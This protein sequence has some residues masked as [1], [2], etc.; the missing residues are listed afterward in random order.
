MKAAVFSGTPSPFTKAVSVEE[1]PTPEITQDEILI[2]AVSYAI[3]PTDWK[4]VE[5][6][7][8]K[9]G[10]VLGSDV[11]GTVVKVGSNVK[12]FQ[13]GDS[14][15]SFV[16]GNTSSKNGAFAQYVVGHPNG[17]IK[18]DAKLS[19][20]TDAAPGLIKSYPGAASV[21]LGLVTIGISFSYCLRPDERGSKDGENYILIW[22]GATASGMLAIQ[23]A[24]LV[25]NLKV[26][27]TAS[28]K[29]HE[30]LKS[31]GADYTFDYNDADV[32]EQIKKVGGANLRFGL[33]TIAVPETFQKVYDATAEV[34]GDLYLDSL[35]LM[36][37]SSITL[38]DKRDNSKIH[39]GKTMAY[40]VLQ[41]TKDLIS[42]LQRPEGLLKYYE[43]WWFNVM[44]K[45]IGQIQHPKLK[46]LP[47]GLQ[48]AGEGFELLKQ[49]VSSEK[50]VFDY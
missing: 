4:H 9:Q 45:Y 33:D 30:Y 27:T 36:D 25:Y 39:Y 50:I 46:V 40:L 42:L 47:K 6:G 22:G 19:K 41:E 49:G 16:S 43:P 31:L 18:Y 1:I 11:S 20:E 32:V 13:V 23:V 38:D 34:S 3:N 26:I 8:A 7:I 2:E 48:S 35:L 15:S 21:T 24:K 44:P 12:N 29:N 5:W 10:N 14:V 28:K 17:T 37:D